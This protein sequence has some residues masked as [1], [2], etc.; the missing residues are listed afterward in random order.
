MSLLG[1][2]KV[3]ELDWI[4]DEENWSIVSHHVVVSFLSVELDSETSGIS[5]AVVRTTFSSHSGEAKEA[6]SLLADLAEEVGLREST[7]I[8]KV[9]LLKNKDQ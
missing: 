5:V 6:W 9:C 2:D 4:L 3:W 8:A 7:G 1:M